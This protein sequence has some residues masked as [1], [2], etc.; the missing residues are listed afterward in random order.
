VSSEK[1]RI[2]KKQATEFRLRQGIGPQDPIRFQSFLVRLKILAVFRPLSDNFSGMSIRQENFQFMLINC[3]QSLGRQN[4]SVA[5]E[6]YHLFV[7]PNN[8]EYHV[9]MQTQI[10]T[11]TERKA[12]RFASQLLLPDAGI[13]SMIPEEELKV[14]SIA[15]PTVLK[16]EQFYFS[17]RHALAIRLR[18]LGLIDA[19]KQDEL[20]QDV[21]RGARSFGF[22]CALYEPSHPC[23]IGDYAELANQLYSNGKM[24]ESHF[25]QLMMDI[26]VDVF[27]MDNDDR[28]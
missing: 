21:K 15:L 10:S 4:F 23:V 6:L 1:E 18:N 27:S 28:L 13:L 12:D 5:H 20:M 14:N 24:S 2:A 25:M 3:A 9:C 16:L 17:S 26:G 19:R 22:D 7:E 8:D 11:E